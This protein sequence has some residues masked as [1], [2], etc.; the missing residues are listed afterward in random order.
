VK[1]QLLGALPLALLGTFGCESL[2]RFSTGTGSYEGVVVDASFVRAGVGEGVRLCLTFDADRIQDR[3]GTI[4]T[5]DGLF[6]KTPL[7]VIPQIWHDPLATLSFG[8][9]RTKN[10]VYTAVDSQGRDTTLFVSLLDRGTVEVRLLRGSPAS[11]GG[12]LFALFPLEKS[13]SPCAY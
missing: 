10:M 11:A 6:A 4:S 8:E 9:G 1:K 13:S 5:S 7:Q 12:G 3:P 2:D